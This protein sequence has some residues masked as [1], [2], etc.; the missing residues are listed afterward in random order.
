MAKQ[1]QKSQSSR[2][3]KVYPL[4]FSPSL[5]SGV[6]IQDT[7]LS[8]SGDNPDDDQ[9]IIDST[10]DG[11]MVYLSVSNLAVSINPH[12]VRC[13]AVTDNEDLSPEIELLITVKT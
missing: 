11:N 3:E 2:E 13:I 12:R 10:I 7:D 5:L 9:P 4:D 1:V 8:Y 6:T